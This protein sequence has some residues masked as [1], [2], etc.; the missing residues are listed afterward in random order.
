MAIRTYVSGDLPTSNQ[1][2]VFVIKIILEE[3]SIAN[4]NSSVIPF[5]IESWNST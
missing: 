2:V 5:R 3:Q 4:N 1:Y